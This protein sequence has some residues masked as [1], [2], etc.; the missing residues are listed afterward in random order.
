MIARIV[1]NMSSTRLASSSSRGKLLNRSVEI[2][3]VV[4]VLD[5]ALALEDRRQSLAQDRDLAR[6]LALG[7]EG[8]EAEQTAHADHGAAGVDLLDGDVVH[9]VAG[10]APG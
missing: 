3:R 9:R 2:A 7:A 5:D 10:D 1:A 6:R 4:R 8:E